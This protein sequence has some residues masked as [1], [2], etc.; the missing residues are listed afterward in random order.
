M[1]SGFSACACPTAACN[2]PCH[3]KYVATSHSGEEAE[4]VSQGNP[5]AGPQ[6]AQAAPGAAAQPQAN[7]QP[8]EDEPPPP[9][10]FGKFALCMCAIFVRES[11]RSC[12]V[13]F[14]CCGYHCIVPEYC[15]LPSPRVKVW[16]SPA[17]HAWVCWECQ[18]RLLRCCLS[19]L[20]AANTSICICRVCTSGHV[21]ARSDMP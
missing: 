20:S 7:Q 2:V 5:S 16:A 6:A 14:W 11:Y 1:S 15:V 12:T 18:K 10:P 19:C 8:E 17:V 13:T 3:Q 9:E 4:M 21:V